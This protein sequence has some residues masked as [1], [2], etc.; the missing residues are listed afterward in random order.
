MTLARALEELEKHA[1]S[2]FDPRLVQV[3][4]NSGAIRKFFGGGTRADELV[5]IG[6]RAPRPGWGQRVAT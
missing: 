4:A 6:A 3:V 5:Q 2:Q 1:G